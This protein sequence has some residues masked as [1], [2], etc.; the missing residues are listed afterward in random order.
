[1]ANNEINNDTGET[2]MKIVINFKSPDA[3]YEII[4]ARHPRSEAK[5]EAFCEEYFE[6]GDYGRIE[7][8]SKTLTARLLPRSE[9]E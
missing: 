7:V 1:L 8:D 6:Y 4:T 2:E 3:I 5:Q 9:W